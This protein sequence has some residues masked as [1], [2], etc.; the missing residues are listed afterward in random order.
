M[1]RETFHFWENIGWCKFVRISG[2]GLTFASR[3]SVN[4]VGQQVCNLYSME[5][6]GLFIS[7]IGTTC[8]LTQKLLKGIP[9]GIV[10]ERQDD[11]ALYLLVPATAGETFAGTIQMVTH[12]QHHN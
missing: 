11:G 1:D 2:W 6:T 12:L 5:H 7:N 4:K 9:H 3:N 8:A 10:L